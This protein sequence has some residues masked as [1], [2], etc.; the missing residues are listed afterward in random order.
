MEIA[1]VST[2]AEMISAVSIAR[3]RKIWDAGCLLELKLFFF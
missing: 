2:S 1:V 3:Y